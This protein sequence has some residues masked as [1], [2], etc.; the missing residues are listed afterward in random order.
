[1]RVRTAEVPVQRKVHTRGSRFGHRE[2]DGED[3]VRPQLR[4]PGGPVEVDQ[5]RVERSLVERVEALHRGRDRG[6]DVVDGDLHAPAAEARRIA[7]ADLDSLVGSGGGAGWHR[8]APQRAVVE[9]H[10]GFDG[11]I[12]TRIEDL[13]GADGEDCRHGLPILVPK[14]GSFGVWGRVDRGARRRRRSRSIR[15]R[16]G[17]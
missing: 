17:P 5:D 4:L 6:E 8:G 11:G 3:R 14:A 15:G 12:P 1:M 10:V 16:N 2:R 7:V 9:T 13:A